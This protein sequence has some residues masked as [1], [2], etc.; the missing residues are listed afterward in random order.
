VPLKLKFNLFYYL[1]NFVT[2]PLHILVIRSVSLDDFDS[3]AQYTQYPSSRD[4]FT[5]REHGCYFG[6]PCLRAVFVTR[7]GP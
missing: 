6:H 2:L 1:F 5:A 7:A 3:L 4:V